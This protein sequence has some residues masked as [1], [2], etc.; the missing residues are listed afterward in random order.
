MTWYMVVACLVPY[1]NREEHWAY[2]LKHTVPALHERGIHTVVAEQ[3]AD[4]KLFNRGAVLNAAVAELLCEHDEFIT[5][6]VDINPTEDTIDKLYLPGLQANQ[7]RGIYTSNC[8]TLAPI[9]KFH[10]K[11]F[12]R[13]GGF[14]STFFGW[15]AEDRVLQFRAMKGG[16]SITKN[17]IKRTPQVA[18]HFSK[19]FDVHERHP[20]ADLPTRHAEVYGLE[21]RAPI[22]QQGIL[23]RAGSY[24]T[25]QY[26][27]VSCRHLCAGVTWLTVELL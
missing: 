17:V 15:G 10:V 9:V 21:S 4:G 14:P 1:R 3:S 5:H 12:R 18:L 2:F 20:P 8:D 11:D 13:I 24:D 25:T 23:E 7:V 16:L 6:D 19:I 22:V 26:K 27:V